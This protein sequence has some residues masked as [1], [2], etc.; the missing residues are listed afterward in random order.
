M[1]DSTVT[2]Q[3]ISVDEFNA[4]DKHWMKFALKLAAKAARRA[5][6]NPHVG[7]VIVKG[8][9]IL[10][11]G[12]TQKVG[13]AHAEQAALS[14][15]RELGYDVA[16]ATAYVT[17]EPC[18]HY[19]RT[20]PC[21]DALIKAGL[22]E[23]V[24][25]TRDPNPRV[26]GGGIEKL[27]NAGIKVRLGLFH[28]EAREM[29]RGF[30]Q[31]MKT[32]R[33]FVIAKMAVSADGRSAI[34]DGESVWITNDKSRADVHKLR[35]L[36]SAV[37]TTART[38]MVDDPRLTARHHKSGKLL[39]R[40]PLRVVLDPHAEVRNTAQT[41]HQPG[42]VLLFVSPEKR[43]AAVLEFANLSNVE[44]VEL[45]AN[46]GQFDLREVFYE[47]GDHEVNNVLIEA[48]AR[49]QGVCVDS[50]MVS[51]LRVYIAPHLMGSSDFG[52]LELPALTSMKDR[53]SLELKDVKKFGQDVR[54]VYRV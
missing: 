49:F 47:L 29:N 48:G 28:S 18:A 21:S 53:M 45:E 4:V 23:V 11:Q 30:I 13:Q 19:G 10:G 17:L 2:L 6:P 5:D 22:T 34:K 42:K 24:I 16:G 50:G 54:L 52:I 27:R 41:F 7:C 25:A 9:E 36:M 8:D 44:I 20:P 38:V 32:G 35:G 40:Q 39:T 3:A 33:P 14:H 1:T 15:A 46:N 37:L 43:Q 26:S 51:E 31:R 12:N